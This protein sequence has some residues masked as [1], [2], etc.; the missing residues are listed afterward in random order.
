MG[1]WGAPK[2]AAK[3]GTKG[4]YVAVQKPFIKQAAP[5]AWGGKSAG[6]SYGATTSKGFGASTFKGKGYGKAA[7][8]A[9]AWGGK[10]KGATTWTAP[11]KGGFKGSF[12]GSFDFSKGKGKGKKGAPAAKS[13]FWKVK[14]DSENRQAQDGVYTGTV[15]S[16][17]IKFGW[18]FILPDNVE[19]LPADVQTMLQ[20]ANAAAKAAGKSGENL[21]YFR[22]PDIVE[23]VKV[24]K[25]AACTFSVYTD[26]K[27]AGACDV[28][29]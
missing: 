14:Q 13:E 20:E 16:Y 8:P 26:D 23:G 24:E 29:C 1:S 4:K 3:G 15:A 2:G 9:P 17:N 27:G 18:G 5:A 12:K 19:E 22:K 25:D 21:L 11:A 28:S 6:K 7:A 10:G